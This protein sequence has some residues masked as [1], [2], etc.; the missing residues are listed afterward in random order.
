MTEYW[1]RHQ[2]AWFAAIKNG[3]TRTTIKLQAPQDLIDRIRDSGH[4]AGQV[5]A[6]TS[7]IVR[8]TKND[9]HAIGWCP[10]TFTFRVMQPSFEATNNRTQNETC[11]VEV[12]TSA[13][14]H[15]FEA[16][17]PPYDATNYP[18]FRLR[19]GDLPATREEIRAWF[20]DEARKLHPDLGGTGDPE[21]MQ[22][23]IGVRNALMERV[24]RG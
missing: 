5:V 23:L 19:S 24:R 9:L 14:R 8:V 7:F 10:A 12:L 3:E 6:R 11:F 16:K 13:G 17:P 1:F 2:G 20:F 4:R 21:A 18:R 22:R 15:L